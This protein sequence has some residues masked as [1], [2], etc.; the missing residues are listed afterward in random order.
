MVTADTR[1]CCSWELSVGAELGT[2]AT[3]AVLHRLSNGLGTEG[4]VTRV[5]AGV[6]RLVWV[7]GTCLRAVD[8]SAAVGCGAPAASVLASKGQA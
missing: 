2:G 5:C 7:G 1:Y 3:A 8:G 4:V 6:Q